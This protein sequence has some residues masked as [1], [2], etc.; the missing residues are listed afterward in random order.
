MNRLSAVFLL[1]PALWTVAISTGVAAPLL[2]A[3]RDGETVCFAGD[4]ITHSGGYIKVLAD[5]YRSRYPG[6]QIRLI[7]CGVGG[8]CIPDL[9]ARLDADVL[10]HR[11]DRLFVMLGMNDMNRRLYGKNAAGDSYRQRRQV[12]RERFVRN[13]EQLLARLQ[14]S[15]VKNI[16]IMSP[17]IYD[18]YAAGR[19]EQENNLGADRS[20]TDFTALVADAARRHGLPFI[21]QHSPMLAVT[22]AGQRRNPS[23]TLLR[24]DRIHPATPGDYQIAERILTAQ[25]QTAS[26]PEAAVDAA[27][28]K[29]GDVV[30][31]LRR[32]ADGMEFQL[33]FNAMPMYLN[34]ETMK[35]PELAAFYARL[36]RAELRITGLKPGRY[37]FAVNGAGLLTASAEE[38]ARGLDL[39]A[40]PTPNP[41]IETSLKIAGL[42]Q[43]MTQLEAGKLRTPLVGAKMV[44]QARLKK[45]DLPADD[46]AAARILLQEKNSDYS[47][48][49]YRHL[50]EDGTPEMRKRTVA[51][52]KRLNEEIGRF[53]QSPVLQCTLRKIP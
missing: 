15:G 8:D 16:V 52:L 30:S 32:T 40:L 44:R 9:L 47:A 51:E 28:L 18:Q 20:L 49:N 6:R 11:P 22:L 1:L 27:G 14:K 39:S 33:N 10:A 25:G 7:N 53:G 35:I 38:F 45:P 23:F 3:F 12:T 34:P 43:K 13:L 31:A 4:S 2:P 26:F 19:P 21:D 50:V 41:W 24:P 17:T 29:G 48:A 46:V 42:N 5:Y 36:N 37:A